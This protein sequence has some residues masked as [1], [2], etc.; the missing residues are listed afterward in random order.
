MGILFVCH[1]VG[2]SDVIRKTAEKMRTTTDEKIYFLTVGQTAENL[3]KSLVEKDEFIKKSTY[4]LSDILKLNKEEKLSIENSALTVEQLMQT[5]KFLDS[6]SVNKALIGTPSQIDA[7]APFQIAEYLADKLDIGCIYN[8]YLYKEK[9][10]SYWKLLAKKEEWQSKYRWLLPL[11]KTAEELKNTNSDL[12]F[13]VV[14]HPSID[15]VVQQNKISIDIKQT[16]ELLQLQ[17][18]TNE[19]KKQTRELL[20]VK[21]SQSLLFISG[22]KNIEDDKA[23]LNDLLQ[24]MSERNINIE[25]RLGIHPGALDMPSYVEGLSKVIRSYSNTSVAQ[26][27][28]LIITDK[29]AAQLKLTE[30]DSSLYLKVNKNG[31][32][33]ANCSDAVACAVPATLVNKAAMEG[34]PAYYHQSDKMPYLPEDRLFVGEKNLASF[35]EKSLQKKTPEPISKEQLELPKEE[36]I[37]IMA[38]LISKV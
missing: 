34:K 27:V 6:L 7:T 11:P 1:S 37:E 38:K 21:Q 17:N 24:V 30:I 10:H 18:K 3:F 15:A 14:G 33:I 23:L 20:Q 5:Q 13:E 9:E 19:E 32:E 12:K 35:F 8:D 4:Y 31:D 28:K 2:D 26:C 25:I 16:D 36:A 22:T 29:V